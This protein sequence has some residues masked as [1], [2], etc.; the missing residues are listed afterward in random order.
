MVLRPRVGSSCGVAGW[1]TYKSKIVSFAK[2]ISLKRLRGINLCGI[3]Q[4]HS[5]ANL[6]CES[7][8]GDE[9]DMHGSYSVCYEIKHTFFDFAGVGC[10][11]H[12]RLHVYLGLV[13]TQWTSMT[14]IASWTWRKDDPCET[15]PAAAS[16]WSRRLRSACSY[17]RVSSE[18]LVLC[19]RI[20]RSFW[21]GVGSFRVWLYQGGGQKGGKGRKNRDN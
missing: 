14:A 20:G 5:Q 3:K 17:L 18:K 6:T 8:R 12:I 19:D 16:S 21:N 9:R 13:C 2:R 11:V 4:Q 1:V 10:S 7:V 15:L